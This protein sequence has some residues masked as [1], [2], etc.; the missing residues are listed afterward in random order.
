MTCSMYLQERV[1]N[2]R[3]LERVEEQMVD[4]LASEVRLLQDLPTTKR[5][6]D[7]IKQ[8]DETQDR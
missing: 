7:L 3:Y 1:E 5:L 2:Q 4:C 6:A 8:Y